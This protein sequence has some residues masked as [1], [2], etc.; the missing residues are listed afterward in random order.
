MISQTIV[1]S[2][3]KSFKISREPV[4]D[5][6]VTLEPEPVPDPVVTLEPEPV[7][8]QVVGSAP[9]KLNPLTLSDHVFRYK[10][11]DADTLVRWKYADKND[12]RQ[13]IAMI[14]PLYLFSE[15]S[16]RCIRT[17]ELYK[18]DIPRII[19][20][21]RKRPQLNIDTSDI[22][23]NDITS[24]YR[25]LYRLKEMIGIFHVKNFIVRV[26]HAFDNSQ[27]R[28]EYCVVH[29]LIK[30]ANYDGTQGIDSEHHVVV[31]VCVQLNNLEKI[32]ESERTLFH[33]IS[34]SIQ[35]FVGKS[36]TLDAWLRIEK[37]CNETLTTVCGQLAQAL[38]YLH[39]YN[40]VHGDI[41]PANTL[42]HI[43]PA[44]EPVLYLIDYGMSGIHD[45]SEGTGGT[46]P[47][48]APETGNGCTKA[49][50]ES[51]TYHWT[52]NKKENDVWSVGI[53]FFTILLFGKCFFY[54]KDY[55]PDF[56]D[57]NTGRITPSYFNQISDE[58]MRDLFR[59]TLCPADERI[60]AV[61]LLRLINTAR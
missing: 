54:Q 37:P 48:C 9:E 12:I 23:L 47:F 7:P 53:M 42:V 36:Q 11:C 34:Y 57:P 14:R 10:P 33:H 41:K 31:P 16:K 51:D 28:S 59:R 26:E 55:P 2:I 32:P 52:K 45:A 8:T 58:P 50:L 6:I 4:P 27:I 39:T 5:P 22:N 3:R 19:L 15:C 20:K 40:I 35:P 18:D 61:D 24:M 56:F 13:L 30:H 60:T 17:Y 43:S 1:H 44:A 46:K 38:V 25:M 49:M 21:I 29:Q